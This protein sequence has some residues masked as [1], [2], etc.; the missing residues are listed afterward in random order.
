MTLLVSAINPDQAIMVGDRLITGGNQPNEW[1][2][3]AVVNLGD[4]RLLIGYTGLARVG[5]FDTHRWLLKAI[6]DC[7]PPDH[8]A[9]A[10]LER[11][12]V[13]ASSD[14]AAIRGIQR[15]ERGLVLPFVAY[16]YS[17]KD[18]PRPYFGQLTNYELLDGSCFSEPS[19]RFFFEWRRTPRDHNRRG[20]PHSALMLSGQARVPA[21]ADS[22]GLYAAVQRR[23]PA[24]ALVAKAVHLVRGAAKRDPGRTIGLDCAS[25]VVPRDMQLD[26][27]GDYHPVNAA[28]TLYVASYV[29][30]RGGPYGVYH[31]N[32]GDIE[33]QVRDAKGRAMFVATPPVGRRKPCYCGSGRRYKDCHGKLKSRSRVVFGLG[34]ESE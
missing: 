1:N 31:V 33:F 10:T 12:A 18:P 27:Q 9:G 6:C 3:I 5:S 34:R 2:K 29:E 30:A 19:D 28:T 8:S 21:K 14:I 4:A 25:V 24:P 13:R 26:A 20:G 22:A 11:L 15:F 32:G 23:E 7:A 17:A 16:V